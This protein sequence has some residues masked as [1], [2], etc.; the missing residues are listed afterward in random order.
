ML[1]S[2]LQAREELTTREF[3][4]RVPL[5]RNSQTPSYRSYITIT[6]SPLF[7][8]QLHVSVFEKSYFII[9][10]RVKDCLSALLHLI[11]FLY[12]VTW[13]HSSVVLIP[14][15]HAGKDVLNVPS[16]I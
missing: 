4:Q 7:Y 11:E 1:D 9:V 16:K 8:K 3:Y 13:K 10:S 15:F 5:E 2:H 12:I 6:A 14:I